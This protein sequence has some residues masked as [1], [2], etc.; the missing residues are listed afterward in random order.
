MVLSC[1]RDRP[2]SPDRVRQHRQDLFFLYGRD[3]GPPQCWNTY[4]YLL[5]SARARARYY[6]GTSRGKRRRK[7]K[8]S[9]TFIIIIIIIRA[10]LFCGCCCYITI[11]SK[12]KS[13]GPPSLPIF[14]YLM[15]GSSVIESASTCSLFF[16]L[17]LWFVSHHGC[18]QIIYSLFFSF[19][20]Y[21]LFCFRRE[22]KCEFN[23]YK[24]TLGIVAF[25][26][27]VLFVLKQSHWK[28]HLSPF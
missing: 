14:P 27:V 13:G 16:L 15:T 26:N 7:R 25:R 22:M 5:K 8:E 17:F 2:V 4:P 24:N 9:L 18:I 1:G 12:K 23:R 21:F 11:D 10:L 6:T 20:I 3:D 28:F 19:C